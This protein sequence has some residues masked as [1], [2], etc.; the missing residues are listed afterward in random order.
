MNRVDRERDRNPF[1]S[2]AG[3]QFFNEF[4]FDQKVICKE[5]AQCVLQSDRYGQ[6]A[7]PKSYNQR[8]DRHSEVVENDLTTQWDEDDLDRDFD[9]TFDQAHGFISGLNVTEKQQDC[10]GRE[11][12]HQ[13]YRKGDK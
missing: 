1:L 6:A 3:M 4:M 13:K 5:I 2:V 8:S 10:L 12:D 11:K 7:D 9:R